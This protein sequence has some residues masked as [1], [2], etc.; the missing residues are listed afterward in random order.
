MRS[1]QVQVDDDVFQFVKAH[2]EP[3]VDDFNSALRRL[4]PLTKSQP[5]SDIAEGT[6]QA[7][8]SVFLS[9]PNGLPKALRYV[10]D[11]T[12][13][14]RS[15]AYSRTAATQFVAKQYNVSPQAVI[16]KYCRQLGQT[17][18]E[19]DSQLEEENLERLNSLLKARFSDYS[20]VIN[21]SLK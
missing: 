14:V 2:A 15:G 21:Q 20:D 7:P 3:L 13:L 1:H 19:F 9:L 16:D 6:K 10:L 12:H 5:R 8:E 4:L 11:V 18:S 17:A